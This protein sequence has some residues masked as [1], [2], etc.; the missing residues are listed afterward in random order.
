MNPGFKKMITLLLFAAMS[1]SSMAKSEMTSRDGISMTCQSVTGQQVQGEYDAERD[2]LVAR[3]YPI[4]KGKKNFFGLFEYTGGIYLFDERIEV[5]YSLSSAWEN[6]LT[7]K[8]RVRVSDMELNPNL[9]PNSP[10]IRRTHY[11][12]RNKELVPTGSTAIHRL[13][14]TRQDDQFFYFESGEIAYRGYG[15]TS[16]GYFICEITLRKQ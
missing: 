2:S 7:K 13:Y 11:E 5:T 4:G 12:T 15:G 3:F 6:Q 14:L 1:S 16:G 10:V 9:M 8:E